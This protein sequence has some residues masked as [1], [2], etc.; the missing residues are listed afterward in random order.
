[1]R[2]FIVSIVLTSL[3]FITM[4]AEVVGEIVARQAAVSFINADAGSTRKSVPPT[5]MKL[6]A[7]SRMV[8]DR[9]VRASSA[10]NIC[11]SGAPSFYIY[12]LEEGGFVIASAEDAC[13]PVFA[14][15][16]EGSIDLQNLPPQLE[17]MLECYEAEVAF[18]RENDMPRHPRWDSNGVKRASVLVQYETA[19]WDQGSPYNMYC[20]TK[21]ELYPNG[22]SSSTTRTITGC[23][24]TAAAIV[25]RYHKWPVKVSPVKLSSYTYDYNNGQGRADNRTVAAHTLSS[26]HNYDNMPLKYTSQATS[27]QNEAVAH[28]M[29]DIGKASKMMYGTNSEGGSGAYTDQLVTALVKYF[30]YKNTAQLVN[31]PSSSSQLNA[32]YTRLQNELKNNG[33]IIYGGVDA[34]GGGHQFVLDGLRDDNYFHVNWGWSGESNGWFSLSSLGGSKVGYTFNLY[35]DA[36]LDLVPDGKDPVVYN[37]D[38]IATTTSLIYSK[39]ETAVRLT[40]QYDIHYTLNGPAGFTAL[41]GDAAA[42]QTTSLKLS[43][44]LKGTYTLTLVAGGTPYELVIKL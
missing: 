32:F 40:P 30:G 39:T 28:L 14:Y 44:S 42:S 36:I 15:S 18:A 9:A 5:E 24:A 27:A 35:Q 11:T 23:V 37:A 12:N 20:P 13:Q 33:P 4:R 22:G 41:E 25:C 43:A 16:H 10:K 17:Y 3:V 34:T 6:V 2:R 29:V 19:S 26:S 7:D 21:K 31:K 38:Q 1:M 8:F